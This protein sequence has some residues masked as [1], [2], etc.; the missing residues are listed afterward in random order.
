MKC[1][2]ERFMCNWQT[3][4]QTVVGGDLIIVKFAVAN[5]GVPG[6]PAWWHIRCPVRMVGRR[7][8]VV[9]KVFA[10]RGAC[11]DVLKLVL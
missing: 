5:K 8:A 2:V 9:V 11:G 4:V 3:I 6:V 7:H 10:A 1:I